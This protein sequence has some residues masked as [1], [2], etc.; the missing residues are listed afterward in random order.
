MATSVLVTKLFIPATRPELV[1]RPRLISRLN[2]GLHRKLTLVSAPAGFGKTTLVT[3]WLQQLQAT[4]NTGE[5]IPNVNQTAWFSLDEEDNDPTRFITYL[6]A[7]LNRSVDNEAPF[8]KGVLEMLQ[9]SQ[10]TVSQTILTTLINEIAVIDSKVILVLD[11][12]HLIDAEPIHGALAFLLENLPPQMHL[13]IATR[14]DPPL[15]LSRLRARDHLTELRAADLRFSSSEAAVFLNQAMGLNLTPEEI[16]AL[17]VRTEGWIA[18]LQLAALSLQ[19]RTDKTRLIESFTGSNRL[20]LDYLIEEVLNQQPEE[21]Q[22]FLLQTAVLD[23]L[24]GSLCDALTGR[25]NGQET[26]QLLESANLFIIPLDAERR[27]Y[28]Y[29]HLL[30]DLLRQR[31]RQTQHGERQRLHRQASAWYVQNSLV[32]QAIEHALQAQEYARVTQ[33]L[34]D[35]VDELWRRGGHAKLRRFLA[36]LPEE[37]IF[38]EPTICIFHAW[39]LFAGGHQEAAEQVLQAAE[40]TL[41]Q[42]KSERPLPASQQQKLLGRVAAIRA[43]M[44]S[45]RGDMS[46]IIAQAR[47]ALDHLPKN[48]LT[49]RS[50]AAITLGDAHGFQGDMTAAYEARFAAAQACQAS[51]DNYFFMIANLKLA[52]TLRAQGKLH[53]TIE[54]CQQQLALANEKGWSQS[55]VVGWCLAVWSEV[56]AELNDLD[57]AL[58]QA[59]TATELVEAGIDLAIRGWT[60]HCL[61]RVL[62]SRQELAEAEAL[63]HKMIEADRDLDVPPWIMH[64][65]E[66]WQ[67]RLWLAQN[68][69][70][71]A[72]QWAAA[73]E[74]ISKNSSQLTVDFFTLN[75]QVSLARVKLAQG[76]LAETAT[77]LQQ[78]AP[79]AEASGRVTAVIEIL[80][81][82][83]LTAQ[84]AG[85]LPQAMVPLEKACA[86]AE[87]NGFVRIFIDQGQPM[88]SLLLEALK[89]DFAPNYMQHLLAALSSN[90]PLAVQ[91]VFS[92][93]NQA[94]FIEPLSERECEVLQC[95]SSGLSNR[96]IANQLYLSLNTVKVHT[97]NIY[98]KLDVHSRI[99]AVSKAK[100]LGFLPPA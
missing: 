50:S 8:G 81:L 92:P 76:R 86:I 97:R 73:H 90:E 37:W 33:L 32:D 51:G 89:Y 36:A 46:E 48:D 25:D 9:S 74:P 77:L 24:T 58:Q 5:A 6:V 4:A 61:I 79:L 19:G 91:P 93:V 28:R 27:W 67:V 85:N 78:I 49:W 95:I 35:H 44:A 38:A 53:P 39:Y 68:N 96:E 99:Q 16:A 55:P 100:D 1:P 34:K 80:L 60:Y 14:E 26:L 52:I 18:G 62:F 63:I 2:S 54:M 94:E 45:F 72:S 65:M 23:R 7:A 30:A 59:Q 64:Q 83:A 57:K 70:T 82:Q 42:L 75:K 10:P 17:E 41:T 29:H 12:Y 47:R 11:D 98:S 71:A 66:M 21:I 22:Q 56:L 3:E 40:Q 88:R 43:F 15:S 87:P 31:L 13:V 20:V 84:A 69:L